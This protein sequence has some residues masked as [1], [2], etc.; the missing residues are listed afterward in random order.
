MAKIKVTGY[1][2]TETGGLIIEAPKPPARRGRKPDPEGKNAARVL[3]D[4]WATTNFT[5]HASQKPRR[6]RDALGIRG[7]ADDGSLRTAV[8]NAKDQA[9]SLFPTPHRPG[10]IFYGPV[11]AIWFSDRATHYR[12]QDGKEI[13]GFAWIWVPGLSEAVYTT[14]RA[15]LPEGKNH[16]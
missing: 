8:R 10:E 12:M 14:A 6:I 5:P 15:V 13:L 4:A 1:F 9:D 7:L 11:G 3:A 2:D 16:P